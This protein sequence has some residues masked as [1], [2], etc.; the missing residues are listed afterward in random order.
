MPKAI[1]YLL[2]GHDRAAV[3][4]EGLQHQDGTICT[5]LSF[6][7]TVCFGGVVNLIMLKE[8]VGGCIPGA[9]HKTVQALRG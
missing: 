8:G 3:A 2:K 9:S 1:F 4:M 5:L 6:D 7:S